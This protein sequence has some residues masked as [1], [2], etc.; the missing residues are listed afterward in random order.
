MKRRDPFIVGALLSLGISPPLQSGPAAPPDKLQAEK[1]LLAAVEEIHVGQID[2]AIARMGQLVSKYPDFKLA[3]LIHGD[4]LSAKAAPLRSMGGA[5]RGTPD[6]IEGLRKEALARISGVQDTNLV[7]D[8]VP[9]L[10]LE[11]PANQK[12]VVT[13]DVKRS[14][15][16]LFENTGGLPTLVQDYYV[17]TGVKGHGKILEGDQRTPIGIYQTVEFLPDPE[18]P[19]K[20]GAG[21]FPLDYPNQWDRRLGRTGYGIWLH[22]TPYETFSRP[23]QASDGCVALS[24]EDFRILM[25]DIGKSDTPVIIA[26]KIQWIKKDNW[27]KQSES[28]KSL[29]HAW[30]QDWESLD[31]S[32]YLQ[33]Y[34]VHFQGSGKNF[35]QFKKHKNRVN[36]QKSFVDVDLDD[37]SI[38]RYPGE[39][40]MMQV[41]FKQKYK[42]SNFSNTSLKKQY[43]KKEQGQWK[44]VYEGPA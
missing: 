36:A 5:S 17:S 34:S 41:T 29:L 37:I 16:Y 9:D 44:I 13:V 14:R 4:L 23:P 2:G 31:T 40:N 33:H 10:F 38:L 12:Y 26:D 30:K 18:L 27:L 11:L 28:F 32:R 39:N 6:S 15:L 24:N 35:D 25:D 8:S 7:R 21:A 22:G 43:W 19:D 3:H 1:I 42:S 20:Y